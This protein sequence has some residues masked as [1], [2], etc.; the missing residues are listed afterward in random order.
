MFT[1]TDRKVRR[2]AGAEKLCLRIQIINRR[3]VC[4]NK[5]PKQTQLQQLVRQPLQNPSGC[6]NQMDSGVAC[7]PQRSDVFLRQLFPVVEQGSVQI[8]G[9][10]FNWHLALLGNVYTS[11]FS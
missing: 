1:D 11:I 5:V 2:N 6:R 3:T 7:R 9:N 8:K 4:K 10:Q